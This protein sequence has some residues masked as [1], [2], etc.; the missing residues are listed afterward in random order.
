MVIWLK[1][2]IHRPEVPRWNPLGP[3]IYIFKNEG[4]KGKIAFFWGWVPVGRGGNK[5]RVIEDEYGGCILYS[6]T[7]LEEWNLLKLF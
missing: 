7:K 4:Q 3:S 2:D 5:E 6:Y 1:H